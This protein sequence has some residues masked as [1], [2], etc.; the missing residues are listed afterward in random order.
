MYTL[1]FSACVLR[2]NIAHYGY[3][4][5][6]T[7]VFG[8]LGTEVAANVHRHVFA[9]RN[10]FISLGWMLKSTFAGS[11]CDDVS[12]CVKYSCFLKWRCL[13]TRPS[14][15][16]E[17]WM[18]ADPCPSTWWCHCFDCGAL[19]WPWQQCVP[20]VSFAFLWG[21]AVLSI[22]S[23]VVGIQTSLTRCVHILSCF[24]I[25]YLFPELWEFFVY[26]R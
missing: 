8:L 10:C 15:I 25:V 23:C 11:Y 20:V 2:S 13:L 19:P 26:S 4:E 9:W 3:T 6:S 14:V 24:N 5:L 7:A 21:L 1:F 16:W 22:L 18:T 12:M 17:S